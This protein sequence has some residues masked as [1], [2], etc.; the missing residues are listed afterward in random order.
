MELDCWKAGVDCSRVEARTDAG[1]FAVER[2]GELSRGGDV[3]VSF[4]HRPGGLRA[5]QRVDKRKKFLA[6]AAAVG[7]LC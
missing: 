4:R 3:G 7:H 2:V 5:H 1:Y 6:V